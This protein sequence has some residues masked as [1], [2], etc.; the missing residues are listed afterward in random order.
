MWIR[1]QET[2]LQMALLELLMKFLNRQ[3]NTPQQRC[4]LLLV[5]SLLIELI[6]Y[7]YFYK[8]IFNILCSSYWNTR[9]VNKNFWE[10]W[11]WQVIETWLTLAK[12]G[13]AGKAQCYHRHCELIKIF[14][15]FSKSIQTVNFQLYLL[16]LLL[17]VFNQPNNYV[18][19]CLLYLRKKNKSMLAS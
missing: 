16:S 11:Q 5:I 17:F 1:F 9:H 19:W 8:F 15:P 12:I 18:N 4:D 14:L 3:M 6:D 13:M 2:L 7:K 10:I